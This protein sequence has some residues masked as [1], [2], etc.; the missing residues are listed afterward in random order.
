MLLAAFAPSVHAVTL[1]NLYETSQ[2]VGASREAAFGEALKTVIVRVSGRRD[3][4]AQLGDEL[5]NPR[6]YVQKFGF[7]ADNVLQ[8]GFDS[9]SVDKLL[10]DAGLPI[11]GRERPATLVMLSAD[12]AGGERWVSAQAPASERAAIERVAAER[13]L[14]LVWASMDAQDRQ[15][16]D[17]Q[18]IGGDASASSEALLAMAERYGANAALIGRARSGAVDWTLISV[19]GASQAT[20]VLADGVHFAADTFARVFAASGSSLNAV[21]VEVAG[22]AGL[23]AYAAALNY[24]ESLTLVR[25]VAV[26]QVSGETLRFRLAVRGDADT[27]RRAI[28]LD[29][30]LLPQMQS[31]PA[32]AVERLSFRFNR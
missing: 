11:W 20:G 6:K 24:L 18:Y 29:N 14:P 13:G 10:S 2:P 7:T 30:R 16:I 3:A 9:V 8:V 25:S 21:I 12:D 19:D 26:E 23:D 17:R 32:S 1:P 31:E 27:L 22:I 4:P 15:Y 28:T 5:R